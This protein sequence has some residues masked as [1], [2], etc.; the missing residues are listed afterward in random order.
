MNK[1]AIVTGAN[2]GLGLAITRA[3]AKRNFKIIMACR[4]KDKA[5]TARDELRQEIP[6]AKLET[7]ILDMSSLDSILEFADEFTQHYGEL[8]LLINNAGITGMPLLRNSQDIELHMATNYLGPFALIGKLLPSFITSRQTRIVNVNSLAHRSKGAEDLRDL[9]WTQASYDPMLA[10]G[11][12]KFALMMFTLELQR[13]LNLAKS[14]TIA[15][16]SHPGFA[17][18]DILSKPGSAM[19]PKTWAGKLRQKILRPLIPT[20]QQAARSTLVAALDKDVKPGEYYGPSGLAEIAGK[21]G[22][23]KINPAAFQAEAALDLWRRSEEI[24]GTRYLDTD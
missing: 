16:S 15:I 4:N 22:H 5:N 12:S 3:L 6:N 17:A 11:R 20:P 7:A 1:T 19:A 18:T 21:P 10:Y 14:K 2:I 9:S 13:R 24:T 8:D 23:A